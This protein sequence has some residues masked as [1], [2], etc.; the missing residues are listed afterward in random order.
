M[1]PHTKTHYHPKNT[2]QQL[3]PPKINL[4][5]PTTIQCIC[6]T[7]RHH[8]K[9]MHH[10][11]PRPKI[12]PLPPKLKLKNILKLYQK[13]IRIIYHHLSPLEK[14]IEYLIQTME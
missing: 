11:T 13:S 1:S 7:N 14:L 5:L 9:Y 6:S 8:P 3:P 2:H 12:Y 4:P 10:Q